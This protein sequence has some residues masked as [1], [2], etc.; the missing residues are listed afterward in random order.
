MKRYPEL[1][2]AILKGYEEDKEQDLTS[3]TP[4]EIMYH[5]QMLVESKALRGQAIPL[6]DGSYVVSINDKCPLYEEGHLLLNALNSEGFNNKIKTMAGKVGGGLAIPL[7]VEMAKKHL[8]N[9]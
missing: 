6:E 7:M 4:A 2:L 1:L 8:L 5:K 3:W 9:L